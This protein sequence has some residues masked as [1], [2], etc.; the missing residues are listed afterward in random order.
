MMVPSL[1]TTP[2]RSPSPSKARPRSAF[3]SLTLAIRSSRFSGLP[4]SGWWLGKVPST[5]QYSGITV[6]PRASI[7]CGAITPAT[8]LPQS[9]T[10]FMGLAMAMSSRI[11]WK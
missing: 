1:V 4:G 2:T 10:T 6:Q 7:S 11:S 9:T 8:P 3:S 5:S